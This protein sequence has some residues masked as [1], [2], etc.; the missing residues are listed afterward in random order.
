MKRILFSLGL[1][2]LANH[3]LALPNVA[4][5]YDGGYFVR[6]IHSGGWI[7]TIG[8]AEAFYFTETQRTETYVDLFDATRGMTVR[9]QKDAMFL[10]AQG[11]PSL[12]FFKWGSW[13]NRRFFGYDLGGGRSGYYLLIGAR[14]YRHVLVDNGQKTTSYLR[15]NG[16]SSTT[17][18]LL[19]PRTDAHYAIVGNDVFINTGASRWVKIYSGSWQ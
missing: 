14:M 12:R 19:F 17:L 1:F 2:F 11:E 18:N 7:E 9:L 16:R 5:F 6:D 10:R 3:A 4:W 15:D 13:D 8:N